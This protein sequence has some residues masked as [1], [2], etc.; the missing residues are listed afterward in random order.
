MYPLF[1]VLIFFLL[2]VS[3]VV[4]L[5]GAEGEFS[6][7]YF[8]KLTVKQLRLFIAERGSDCTGCAEKD[9]FV[10]KAYSVRVCVAV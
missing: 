3:F 4:M 5:A 8:S 2:A 10:K 7:E 6:E 1:S 9:E